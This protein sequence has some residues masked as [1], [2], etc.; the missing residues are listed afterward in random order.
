MPDYKEMYITLFKETTKTISILQAAQQR[1]EEIYISDDTENN[2]ILLKP[3]EDEQDKNWRK[4]K[5]W[6]SSSKPM[7]SS[8]FMEFYA[9][10]VDL[11]V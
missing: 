11:S 7:M 1:T 8:L 10:F 9:F 4:E 2:L 3:H 5:G 6:T